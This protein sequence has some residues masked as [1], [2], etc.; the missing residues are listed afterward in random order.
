MVR[1]PRS[2]VRYTARW[3][4]DEAKLVR[5]IHKLAIHHRPVWVPANYR[6][7]EARGLENKQETGASYLEIGRAGI[8]A[9]KA[10]E[11]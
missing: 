5:K 6:L 1:I 11:A 8:T 10:K 7:T 4:K 3:R 2:L 9:E